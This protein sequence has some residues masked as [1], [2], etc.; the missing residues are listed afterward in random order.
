MEKSQCRDHVPAGSGHPNSR[1]SA[2]S[3]KCSISGGREDCP[4]GLQDP[5][6]PPATASARCEHASNAPPHGA[7]R[8]IASPI[9]SEHHITEP[10]SRGADTIDVVPDRSPKTKIL[11]S[12]RTSH[13][14]LHTL[15]EGKWRSSARR[16]EA[17][18]LGSVCCAV[19]CPMLALTP[20]PPCRPADVREEERRV[21]T[22]AS[23]RPRG[24]SR[25]PAYRT[26]HIAPPDYRTC[27]LGHARAPSVRFSFAYTCS[28]AHRNGARYT[29][30]DR[31]TTRGRARARQGG[32]GTISIEIASDF[33][34]SHT[35]QTGHFLFDRSNVRFVARFWF[36]VVLQCPFLPYRSIH[37]KSQPDNRI[38]I[39][40]ACS[41]GRA[42]VLAFSKP[43]ALSCVLFR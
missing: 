11:A 27:S 10:L 6:S 9:G 8:K 17:L 23:A 3:I 29:F 37:A 35:R 14:L 19:Q 38:T 41:L 7:K 5:F 42:V 4:L 16:F 22:A 33:A 24:V 25:A 34:K 31:M 1:P 30:V 12:S 28:S 15:A 39:V 2:L 36:C 21:E 32:R 20:R 40:S 26:C 18:G 13:S 43:A